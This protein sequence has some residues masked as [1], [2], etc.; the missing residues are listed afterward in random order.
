MKPLFIIA[1]TRTPFSRAGSSLAVLDAVDLGKAAVSALLTQSGVDPQVVDETIFGCV[2]QPAHAQNIARV[3]ALRAGLPESKPAMT[4]HRNCASGLEALTTAHARMRADQGDVFII[5]GTESMSN[6]PLY[7]SRSAAEKF[8]HMAK[9]RSFTEKL[10]A[11]AAFRPADFA[12]L[13]GLKLGL[14]DPVVEMNMGETAELLAREFGITRDE[15]DAFALRSHLRAT[16]AAPVVQKEIAP[17]YVMGREVKP[18]LADNG[19]RS[20]SSLE[21]LASLKPLF[22]REQGTVTA[23]NSSQITD[24]AV[25]L[26]VAS[27]EAVI[28]HDWQPLGRLIDYA[29]TGCD[30][31][32]MGL[33]PVRAI[34][35]VLHRT[36]LKLDDMDIVEINEAFA[37]Q[38]LA[39]RQCL[40]NPA[41]ARRAGLDEP[42]GDIPEEKLNPRG[43]SIA[44]GHPVG[45]T[46]A[47]LVLSALAQLRETKT[48]HALVSLCIGGGQG[49]AAIF[50]RV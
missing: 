17:L 24:G 14:T 37:A 49:G 18:V 19:I 20:D 12:P 38:V 16:S 44:L 27:E 43:G 45:A 8:G 32:R 2:G 42:L 3:I 21:K 47:R 9:A 46:G 41:S 1:A 40:K 50:E 48:R 33:G 6:M 11:A 26:L 13:I 39:V 36:G 4:V 28:R 29:Y 15:Q 30:P 23:G 7:F 22:N 35:A 31:R 25:A 34:D 10:G 5:G